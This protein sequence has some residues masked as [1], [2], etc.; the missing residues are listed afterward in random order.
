[1]VVQR[2]SERLEF[3]AA[4]YWDAKVEFDLNIAAL[5]EMNSVA[6]GKFLLQ[7]DANNYH[8]SSIISSSEDTKLE[9]VLVQF[10]GL[11][12]VTGKVFDR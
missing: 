11:R 2:E 6:E 4:E 12:P 3:V 1:M 10:N 8:S 7:H 5:T 9:A